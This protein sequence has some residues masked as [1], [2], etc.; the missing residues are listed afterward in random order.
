MA[1]VVGYV[2]SVW[3]D[4][5]GSFTIADAAQ[6]ATI[7]VVEDVNQFDPAGGQAQIGSET[8]AY[9]AIDY[10]G[11]TITLSAPLALPVFSDTNV[12]TVPASYVKYANVITRDGD[13]PIVAIVSHSLFWR[14]PDGNRNAGK[15]AVGLELDGRRWFVTDI[16]G[17][18]PVGVS[19][20]ELSDEVTEALANAAAN[21]TQALLDAE[22]AMG[23]ATTAN[24]TFRQA[25]APV[26]SDDLSLRDG[27]TWFDTDD[28]NKMYIWLDNQWQPA[29]D[30]ITAELAADISAAQATAQQA[31]DDSAYAISQ[32]DAAIE[33]ASGKTTVTYSED[34]LGLARGSFRATVLIETLPAA[35]EMDEILYELRDHMAGLNCGR[36]DYIFSAIKTLRGHKGFS[37]PDRSQV[38]MDKGFL[39]AYSQLLIK[40]CHRRG[41]HAM[42]GMAAQIPL[43]DPVANEARSEEHTSELQSH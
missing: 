16:M 14:L 21:A 27:D 2:E 11:N 38:T 15:E 43:K 13:A 6:G 18:L 5:R 29:E 40:T 4:R 23:Y 30:I 19:T 9:S 26:D 31:L 39:R 25:T 35:F 7:L 24:R 22:A 8:V 28:S 12:D 34:T 37:L 33:A 1:R 3:V 36:W 32:G 41:A 20:D 10:V 17:E 42:G